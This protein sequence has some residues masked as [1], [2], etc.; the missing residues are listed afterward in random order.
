[1][2]R[3]KVEHVYKRIGDLQVLKDISFSLESRETKVILGA[4]G[5]GKTTILNV[6]SGIMRP[7]SGRVLKNGIDITDLEINKRNIGFVFQD[8][9]LF[10]SMTAAENIAYGLRIRGVEIGEIDRRVREMADM[11]SLK[12][13]LGRFPSQLSGGEKQ[14]VALARTLITD[15]S[16]LLM[17]EP[18][19]SLDS[20]HRNEIRWYIK[21]IPSR[22]DVSILYV[23]HDI[24]DAE[25]LAD[26]IAILHEGVIIEEGKKSEVFNRP[27]RIQTA[28][29]LG[30]N[31]FEMNGNSYA[32]HPTKVL[33]GG[34]V[35]FKVIH[36]ERGIWNNYLVETELGRIS[37]ITDR[38]LTGSEG[39]SLSNAV[40][41]GK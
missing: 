10:Y 20:F 31:L 40:L 3:L 27:G 5:S 2:E 32:V 34:P 39:I 6:I 37:I 24:A 7:D 13:Q 38:K 28:R 4:S 16:L 29:I 8:L 22:F 33:I 30:F 9:G 21:D 15:P 35:A 1:M 12:D 25:I 14:R 23:T 19:S 18:L 36:E 41:L 11:F 17:D 26:S